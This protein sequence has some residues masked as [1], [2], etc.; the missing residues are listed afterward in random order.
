MATKPAKK[1]QP[2]ILVI[3][4]DDIGY[5]NLSAYNLGVMGYRT[6]NIDRLAKEG[7]LFTDYYAQ[8]SCTAGRAAFITGQCPFRTGLT[9][10][11]MPGAKVGLQ[12]EDPTIADLVKPLGYMTGQFGKNHLGDRDEFLPTVHGFDEFFGNLY[13]LNAEEEPENVDYPKDPA[14]RQR[15]G[16]RGVL[17]SKADGKGGQSVQDTGPLTKK[18]METVDEEFLGATLDF[19]DRAQK[20]QKPFFIWFNTTRMHIHTHLKKESQGK[21]GFGLYPDGMVEHD[22]HVGRLLDKL[23]QLGIADDTIVVYT[24]DNGAMTSMWPDGGMTPFRGE[25]DTNWEGA[26][27]AP[28]VVRWPGV[29]KPGTQINELFSSED[30][31]PTLVSAAG[32]PDVV[33]KLLDGHDAGD[34]HFKVHMDGYDQT[35]LLSGQSQE[36]KREEFFYFGDDGELVAMRYKRFKLVFEEQNAKGIEVWSQPFT[37]RRVPLIFD[38]RADPLER[39]EDSVGYFSWMIDRAFVFVP[40][41]AVVGR[42]LATFREFPS[43]QHPSSFSIDQVMATMENGATPVH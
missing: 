5:W 21:T 9:K 33:Q 32:E 24:T 22:G 8:Q 34:K 20:D 39:S 2:N 17:K 40:A 13:H 37:S 41:Q 29:V 35:A 1:K 12:P 16:P 43:R 36:S 30:W 23:D 6:P 10:V 31:L 27:R 38:L 28:C 18:R 7:A 19:I 14:F 42:F 4:G 3:F 25:K 15:F 26:F 11:G